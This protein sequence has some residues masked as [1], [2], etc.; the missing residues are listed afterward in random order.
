MVRL[1]KGRNEAKPLHHSLYSLHNQTALP[2][3]QEGNKNLTDDLGWVSVFLQATSLI[4]K[5]NFAAWITSTSTLCGGRTRKKLWMVQTSSLA[6]YYSILNKT[7]LSVFISLISSE[8][9]FG[10]VKQFYF[11]FYFCSRNLQKSE[12][13]LQ[14]DKL[15]NLLC[16]SRSWF[17]PSDQKS[18]NYFL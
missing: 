18:S 3:K 7:V 5:Y 15:R 2:W 4:S 17:I 12:E 9:V 1:S 16:F 11:A 10:F 6:F 13:F 14:T 8:E